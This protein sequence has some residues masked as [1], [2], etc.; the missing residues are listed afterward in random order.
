MGLYWLESFFIN[1]VFS[2]FTVFIFYKILK[3]LKYYDQNTTNLSDAR[4]VVTSLGLIFSINFFVISLINLFLFDFE[5]YLPNRFYIFYASIIIFSIISFIDD[6]RE[7]DAKIKLMIQ[8]TLVYF[9]LTSL[10][11]NSVALPL[12]L[13]IFIFLIIWTYIINVINFYHIRGI[14]IFYKSKKVF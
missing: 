10:D 8:L 7:I 4:N 1:L 13:T 2:F 14:N 12:K 9:S 11:L 5:N 6:R 3:R